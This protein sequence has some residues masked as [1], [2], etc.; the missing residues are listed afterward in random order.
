MDYVEIAKVIAPALGV[1][2]AVLGLV[3][4][5]RKPQNGKRKTSR[6]GRRRR[7]AAKPSGASASP[8]P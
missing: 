1:V 2:A 3:R 8:R 7:P 6:Q 5:A 4:E